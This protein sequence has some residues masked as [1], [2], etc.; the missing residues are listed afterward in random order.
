[1]DVNLGWSFCTGFAWSTSPDFP[2]TPLA[3]KGIPAPTF[4]LGMRSFDQTILNR[5]HQLSDEVGNFN[6]NYGMKFIGAYIL[7]AKNIADNP[8]EPEWKK[9][10]E[11]EAV[12][13]SLY[14]RN[15]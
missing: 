4:S 1:M 11:F 7:S 15:Q 8:V 12:G 10:D 3:E 5:Y 13:K 9:G 2:N 6:L 14:Q